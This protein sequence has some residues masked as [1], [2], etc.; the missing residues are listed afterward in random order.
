MKP[1][2]PSRL[3]SV[4]LLCAVFAVARLAHAQTEPLGG[5]PAPGAKRSVADLEAQVFYQRAFEAVVWSQ[6]AVMIYRLREGMFESLGMRDHDV[7]AMSH[8]LTTR[9]EVLTANNTT[10]YILACADLRNGPVV[11]EVPA[12]TDKGLLYGQ[13]ADAWQVTIA[14]VG[15][16][17][18]DEG[19][20]GKYL[21]LPPGYTEPPPAGYITV[22]SQSYRIALVF[23]SIKRPGMTDAD[24]NA[25]ARTLKV[26][27]LSEAANPPPTRFIDGFDK[28]IRTLPFY[29]LRYFEDL[30][31]IVSVEPVRPRDKVMMGMLASIG[32][33]PGKPFN[34]S[35]KVKAAMERAVV[36]AYFYMQDRS[37]AAQGKNL[38]WPD[39]H[40]AY[41][42]L[43]DAEGGFSYET[44]TA[45]LFDERALMYHIATLYPA[46]LPDKPAVVYL[47][48]LADSHGRPLAA[49]KNYRLR[50]PKDVPV[51]QF[52]SLIVYDTATWAFIYNPIE[53]VGLS[54]YDLA[55]MKANPD[56]SFDIYFG[57]KAPAR[58]ESNW[59]PTQGKRPIPVMRLYGPDEAFWNKSFRLPDPVMVE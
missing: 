8:P 49:G 11:V 19:K 17:G 57:P 5:Q 29:D 2:I 24:A 33:E 26:Y 15:P 40:W 56:G 52:W 43:P 10:P 55:T 1:L 13:V 25:Y 59:I 21:F 22:P 35:P 6:P 16:S 28:R 32:I 34:P 18:A 31:D 51:R 38:F 9:H 27:P 20:G 44:P 41:F 39:Q 47:M 3:S 58:L 48:G 12:A 7:L 36:D 50:V 23:R 45:L 53:R 30:H 14:D 37:L 4:A 46:K 42:F 54:A